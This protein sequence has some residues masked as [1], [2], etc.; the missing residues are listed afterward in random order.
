MGHNNI[1]IE[2]LIRKDL[3][4]TLT[5][6]ERI[7]LESEKLGF[8]EDEYDLMEINVLRYLNDELPPDPLDGWQP[9]MEEIIKRAKT[10]KRRNKKSRW[11]AYAA[12]AIVFG[13]LSAGLYWGIWRDMG[14]DMGLKEVNR[15]LLHQASDL[16]IPIEE[17]TC[18]IYVTGSGW[19]EVNK[20]TRGRVQKVGHLLVSRADDG[21]LEISQESTREE[22]SSAINKIQIY[23]RPRQQCVV[24]LHNG[25][26][27]RM[28]AQTYLEYPLN[29]SLA[30]AFIRIDGEA[31]VEAYDKRI[32]NTLLIGTAK[33]EVK[34][35]DG[36][37]FIRANKNESKVMLVDG[38]ADLY[39]K[40]LKK[41]LK[42]S[43]CGDLGMVVQYR[44][45]Q[46]NSLR[47]TL[48]FSKDQDILEA[49]Q[50]TQKLRVYRDV[51]L[52]AFMYEMSRW[53]G[54]TVKN[55]DCIPKDKPIT[56]SIPYTSGTDDVLA[57][58]RDAGV[59]LYQEKTMISF[60]PDDVKPKIALGND[61]NI[62]GR[63]VF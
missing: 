10:I 14:F 16:D 60:C 18:W 39:V 3:L 62:E 17:S 42:L 34:V 21:V 41:D 47:D 63:V 6:E 8:T 57:A 13:L 5:E 24:Q 40:S 45:P 4:G 26:R 38:K 20:E 28:N 51:P 55:W 22:V 48:V 54:F 2:D 59:L 15:G 37:F 25:S 7:L 36:S 44:V 50:W 31:Y 1:N 56:I 58:I 29:Q 61:D 32:K 12:A 23:T 49:R 33:G 46:G 52:V 9:D 27:I 30:T 53:E 35:N 19:V 11:R 43:R